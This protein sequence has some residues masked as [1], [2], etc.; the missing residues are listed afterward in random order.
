MAFQEKI[1]VDV[2]EPQHRNVIFRPQNLVMRGEV[3][4]KNLK[5]SANDRLFMIGGVIPGE[6]FTVDFK[7][8]KWSLTD[9]LTLKENKDLAKRIK[10]LMAADPINPQN[11]SFREEL[12]GELSDDPDQIATWLWHLWSGVKEGLFVVV[13][14]KIPAEPEI[15][16]MGKIQL[17]SPGDKIPEKLAE[18]A[19]FYQK[20][21]DKQLTGAK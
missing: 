6:R 1:V 7:N 14:G 13:E 9:K 17:S 15:R 3:N 19:C 16:R 11:V 20:T 10:E 21:E 4:V 2:H 8:L 12:T 18:R 5:K